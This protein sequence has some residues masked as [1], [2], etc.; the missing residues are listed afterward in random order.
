M[1]SPLPPSSSH[2]THSYAVSDIYKEELAGARW[3][4]LD[5]EGGISRWRVLTSNGRQQWLGL[6]VSTNANAWELARLDRE[7]SLASYLD[8]AFALVPVA[9]LHTAQGPALLLEDSNRRPLST[10]KQGNASLEHFLNLAIEASNA[11][12]QAHQ[13]GIVHGDIRPANLILG[14]DGSIRLSGFAFACL[15][16]SPHTAPLQTADCSLAFL[17]PEL[18]GQSQACT[19]HSDL[20]ALGVTFFYLLTGHLPF[21]ANDAGQW[22]HQHLAVAAPPLSTWRSGV[23]LALQ[24]LIAALLDKRPDKRPQ[25][26]QAVADQLH[27]F[28]S[29]WRE[30]GSLRPLLSSSTTAA[31]AR[32]QLDLLVGRDLE[33]AQLHAAVERLQHGRGSVVL[34]QGD[35][36]IGKSALVRHLRRGQAHSALLVAQAKCELSQ[37]SQP[38]GALSAALSSLFAR[39]AGESPADAARW[40]QTLRSAL[41]DHGEMVAR[42]VPELEWLT[43]PLSGNGEPPVSEARRHLHGMLARLLTAIASAAHPLLLF[44][45]DLQWVDAETLS[46]LN[47]L[48][49]TDYEHLLLLVAFRHEGTARTKLAKLLAH[50]ERLDG[51][52]NLHLQPLDR[53]Q[54]YALLANEIDLPA[55]EQASLAGRLSQ[56]GQGNPL[57]ISQAVAEL[58]ERRG[59]LPPALLEDMTAVL[60]ARLVRLPHATRHLLNKLALLGNQTPSSELAEVCGIDP[61]RLLDILR[62]ALRAGLISEQQK[63]ISFTHDSV[64]ETLRAQVDQDTRNASHLEFAVVLLA[65]LS[66]NS[67][68]DEVFRAVAQVLQCATD[69]LTPEQRQAFVETLLRATRLAMAAAAAATALRYIRHASLLLQSLPVDHPLALEVTQRYAYCLILNAE[70]AAADDYL[71]GLLAQT[72]TPLERAEL[73]RLRGE[74][75]SLRGDYAGAV[76]TAIEGLAA[77][78]VALEQAPAAEES[79]AAWRVV[80]Q[81]L[82]V[83]SLDVFDCLPP[84]H[85]PEL[86]AVMALLAAVVIPGSFIHPHLML[87]ASSRVVAL[88]LEHGLNASSV[89][90]LAWLGVSLAQHF[91]DL[92]RGFA[93]S[94]KARTL[95]TQPALQASQ[96]SAL[97]ALDQVS[98]WTRPLPFALDCAEAAYRLSMD[99]G[100]PSFACYANNHIVSD[101]LVLGAPIERML[102]QIDAGLTLARHLEFADAQNILYTQALYIRRLAGNI[103]VS[104]AI[105]EPEEIARRVSVSSMGPLHFWWQLFEG[106]HHFL[107][108]SLQLASDHLDRAWSVAWSAPVHIHQID[109]A[110]F[111]VLVRA[112]IQTTTGAA[113]DYDTPLQRLRLWAASNPRYFADR[114]ALAEAEVLRVQGR[115]M[116]ALQHFE[117]AIAKATQCGAV[118]IRGLAHEMESR[119]LQTLGLQFGAQ[120]HLRLARDAWRRWGANKL[121]E[122]LEAAYPHLREQITPGTVSMLPASH[123]LERASI[124]KA[125]LA[126][127]REIEPDALSKALLANAAT[128]AGATYTALLLASDG[129]LRVEASGA[130]SSSGID[131]RLRPQPAATDAAPMSVVRHVTKHRES[132]VL[133]GSEALRRFSDDSYLLTLESASIACIPLLKQN[134]I[135][136]VLY[137]EN[138][139]APDV[140]DPS[141]VNT[142]E[143]LAAQAA[144][145]L[146]NARLYSNLV[147]EN[148]RRRSSEDT[149]RRTQALMALGQAVSRYGTF[150]WR[151]GSEPS[152]W[153]PRLLEELSLPVPK[154]G[155]YLYE[156]SA[157][158]HA[159]D[160]SRVE[161]S[162]RNAVE[163]QQ[164]FRLA[165]RTL[166]LDGE[167]RFL[168]IAGEPDNDADAII[169]VVSD[170]TVRRQTELALRTARSELDRTA[171]AAILGELSASIAHE[172]N[173]P[174]ASILSNAG[175]SLRWLQRPSPALND[176]LE[177][178]HDIL[179]QAQRAADIVSAMRALANQTAL[180]RK[181]V[182]VNQL[183]RHVLAV[184]QADLDDQNVR[185]ALHLTPGMRTYGDPVQLHQVIHNLITNAAEAMH[186]LQPSARQLTLECRP[187]ANE[188]LVIVEDAGPGVAPEQQGQVFQAFYTTKTS[189]MGMGLAICSSII[190]AHGGTLRTTLGRHGESLFFF[191]LPRQPLS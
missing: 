37:H 190:A 36:G 77:L 72:Q 84:S 11:L 16:D 58:R 140:F 129:V 13:R 98:A 181:Q 141:R 24:Q 26:A 172:I 115:H 116:E 110:M 68:P 168:E 28:L 40:G 126:L 122:Q 93:L 154:D 30:L 78:G 112:A 85:D 142:L 7:Y 160:R 130:A 96:L 156:T 177:G 152:L 97:L 107:E 53:H 188:I 9:R 1:N 147:E 157:L 75:C 144:I 2:H 162:L 19:P 117:D 3:V 184:F 123:E 69:E 149:L 163:D 135:V 173:Q 31:P 8:K 101:L 119:L 155:E 83:C 143:L 38:Y 70:Y 5:E 109:L 131:I 12:A 74:I 183:I 102:H 35:A 25:S 105:P 180:V 61:H 114:L 191:T 99:Q 76:R 171:Q 90:G 42:L 145:S 21:S 161:A 158:A 27:R 179:G 57:L 41:G 167:S 66:A 133:N 20:Y 91:D 33:L 82:D 120:T 81:R 95:A 127:S 175:A 56:Q 150:V 51:T 118:H 67:E 55:A 22:L 134:E 64:F 137:L 187:V 45:D 100:V 34:L 106:L 47:E 104:E 80:E 186:N 88:T 14:T 73:Y 43:G 50:F 87:L 132:L 165:F 62:P 138:T 79:E 63:G 136:G 125:C 148:Q 39:L 60:T 29:E 49:A 151:P 23:P 124:K 17:S 174:L 4:L 111:T 92:D 103:Q 6:T 32:H 59:D 189:G 86:Q 54:I 71:S 94:E 15:T 113:Q 146:S 128:H 65:R 46:F 164:G 52:L 176:A 182:A 18:A 121:A 89:H 10:L 178:I 108:G 159:D 185:V 44:I 153:S 170:I 139:L 169:G 48:E 166:E